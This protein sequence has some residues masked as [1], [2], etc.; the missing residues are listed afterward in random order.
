MK[1]YYLFINGQDLKSEKVDYS[2]LAEEFILNPREVL[3]ILAKLKSRIDISSE[4]E[5]KILGKYYLAENEHI[6]KAIIS[7]H[8]AFKVFKNF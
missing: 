5:T 6:E 4:E 8:E 2:P 1:S 3:R 7:S